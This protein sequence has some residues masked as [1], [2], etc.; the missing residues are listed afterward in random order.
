M[1]LSRLR[2]EMVRE[3]RLEIGERPRIGKI[4]HT[5]SLAAGI[6]PD[7]ALRSRRSLGPMRSA[8]FAAHRGE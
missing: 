3:T 2:T 6:L 8:F 7:E 4:A 1:S 5:S